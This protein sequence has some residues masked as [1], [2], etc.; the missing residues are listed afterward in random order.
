MKL[1]ETKPVLICI[2]LQLGFLDEDIWG[3]NRNNKDSEEVCSKIIALWRSVNEKIIHVRHSSIDINSK[4]HASN[5]G[6][7]FNPLCKP[8]KDETILTKSVNSCFIGTNLRDTLD[9]MNC[10]TVVIVGL[11]TDHCVS[12]TTRMA[13][14]FGYDTYLISDATATFDKLG[15]NGEIFDSELIHKTAL[16]SLNKEFATVISSTDLFKMIIKWQF[17]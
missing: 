12:T 11:T 3:G 6:F 16:A 15:Q 5:N 14:N 17:F 9:Q 13:G 7:R 1:R 8:I 2:D 10:N 4:L